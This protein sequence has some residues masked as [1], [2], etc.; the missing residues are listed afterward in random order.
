MI[1]DQKH[2][3]ETARCLR[4]PITK[5]NWYGMCHCKDGK[6]HTGHWMASPIGASGEW[7]WLLEIDLPGAH[8]LSRSGKVPSAAGVMSRVL[9][10]YTSLA[11][12]HSE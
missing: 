9:T 6:W 2:E 3:N 4:Q 8:R 1:Y 5:V 12:Q 7:E 11:R 10:I